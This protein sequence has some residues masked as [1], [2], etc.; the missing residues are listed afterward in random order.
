VAADFHIRLSAR[1]LTLL[2]LLFAINKGPQLGWTSVPI[3]GCLFAFLVFWIGF[4]AREKRSP[5]PILD[6]NLFHNS[7]C[8]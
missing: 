7:G 8:A 2:S 5:D 4:Y 1:K 6:L 3:I